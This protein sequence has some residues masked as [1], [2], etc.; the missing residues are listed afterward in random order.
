MRQNC[1]L[2][3]LKNDTGALIQDLEDF[4]VQYVDQA[5]NY[6]FNL[7]IDEEFVRF[8]SV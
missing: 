6:G 5:K 2:K 1:N 4:Q 3:R 7:E 8:A